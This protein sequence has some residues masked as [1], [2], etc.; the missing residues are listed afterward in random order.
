[1]IV[2]HQA[3]VLAK[4]HKGT[5]PTQAKANAVQHQTIV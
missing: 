5:H 1:M 3:L 4:E 2:Y